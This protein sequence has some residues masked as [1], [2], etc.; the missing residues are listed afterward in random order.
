V[1][2]DGA[3]GVS[4]DV[5]TRRGWA[6]YGT[7][8]VLT[9]AITALG[10][11][12]WV[13]AGGGASA[14]G[15]LV[16]DLVTLPFGLGASILALRTALRGRDARRVL[17]A[18]LVLGAA[19]LAF[20]LGDVLWF[21]A[22]ATQGTVPY[23]SWADVG[24]LAYYPLLLV[25]LL[26]LA[27]RTRNSVERLKF[28]LDAGAIFL[29]GGLLAWYFVLLPAIRSATGGLGDAVTIAYPVGDLLLLLGVATLVVRRH[30]LSS[31]RALVALML[32]L[33]LGFATDLMY[34]YFT[35]QG[36]YQSGGF[37]DG[38]YLASWVFLS[39]AAQLEFS[40]S[41]RQAQTQRKDAA[42]R[43]KTRVL[44]YL[45]IGVGLA[46]LIYALRDN[47][48]TAGSAAAVVAVLV[49]ILAMVRQFIAQ[50]ESSR[51][52]EER[53]ALL[54]E[55]RLHQALQRT[56][57]SMDHADD[58]M[59]WLDPEGRVLDVNESACRR[60]EYSREELLGM[61]IFDIDPAFSRASDNWSDHW[62]MVKE[63]GSLTLEREQRTKSGRAFPAEITTNYLEFDGEKYSCS[64]YRDISERKRAEEATRRLNRE[65]RA[66]STCNQA[67]L[68]AVDEQTLLNEICR[69]V[70]EKAGYHLAWVGYV[71]HDEAKTVRPVA[72]AGVDTGYIADAKL[73]WED[74]TERG[75]GP[76]GKAIRSGEIIC[77][78]D[79]T[80]DPQMSPWRESVLR[81]GYRSGIALPLKD[82]G[83][84]VFG[85][86]LMYSSEPN[87]VT[88]DEIRLMEELAGD[89]AFGISTLRTRAGRELAE[90]AL[91]ESEAKT[92]SILD[93]IGIG[94]TLISPKMEILE[95]NGRIREWFPGVDPAQRP[96]CYRAF[97]DPPRETICDCCPT[98]RTLQDGL[99]HEATRQTQRAGVVHESRII[100]SPVLGASGEVTAA[101]EMVEDVTEQLSL[102]SQ[103]RQ[104]QKMEAIG[105]LA[106][107]VAHDFNNVLTAIIG[108]SEMILASEESGS[109]ALR[110]DVEEIKAAGERASTLTRQILAFSRRQALQPDV[111]QLND[112]LARTERLLRRALGEDVDFVTRLS[113]DL[114]LVE[115]DAHQFEQVLL[116]LALNSRDA[117]PNG[118]KL[119]LETTNVELDQDYWHT[120]PETV[121]GSYV[122]LALSDS[123]CGMNA[124]TLS[125]IFE[126]FFTTKGQG[127]GTGLGL[128]TVYGVVKQSGGSITVHSEP[129]KGTT[130]KVYLPRVDEPAKKPLAVAHGS[131]TTGGQETILVV[132]DEAGVRELVRRILTG[133][134]YVV[135]GAGDGVEALASM[136]ECGQAIDLLLTDVVLPGRL[137]GNELAQAMT[138]LHPDMPVLYMSGYTRDG[139]VHAGR[140]DP[141]VNY[142]EKPF[143]PDKLAERVRQALD[144]AI[145]AE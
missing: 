139:I 8:I 59:V 80:T 62:Q 9:L 45:S 7:W 124:D 86:L 104:S 141:G 57:F 6:D 121:P 38:G 46:V 21:V 43:D 53:A 95:V 117:M 48:R 18:W 90:R 114:G 52:R 58:S 13:S 129:D 140:L 61:T 115:V 72:W 14:H 99:V 83:A 116:N 105:Q 29:G 55:E 119:T 28:S 66:I 60:W 134:G 27:K 25:G 142:I 126:P 87:T 31:H 144:F 103:L 84:E 138:I 41:R 106:G 22:D 63:R 4:A 88:P 33:T 102:E 69:V 39:L 67:L 16:S 26:L 122:M 127:K 50:R 19:F 145:G 37:V 75:Q 82:E 132:E 49:T 94:V 44:P 17:T 1:K 64:F 76:A 109:D 130:F 35:I 79:F 123:G 110:A 112:I 47:F 98:C 85:V 56:Q 120:H 135:V 20:W 89:L 100:S 36:T 73:T 51:L 65:L 91:E 143:S 32:G 30:W 108:Y 34:G 133:L 137:Q 74:D 24:Y 42:W 125:H 2:L 81:Y 128:S 113:P 40:A 70:C 96:I 12:V 5:N 136:E 118:G 77:V 68:R 54:S 111:L 131:G 92:R 23:P 97:N 101:I 11:F 78:Q 10:Y 71:E 107:G 3:E 93:N 15:A